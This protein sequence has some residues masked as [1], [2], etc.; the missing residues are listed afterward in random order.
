M[1]SIK[2]KV[3]PHAPSSNDLSVINNFF[4]SDPNGIKVAKQWRFIGDVIN[5]RSSGSTQDASLNGLEKQQV[6]NFMDTA[7]GLEFQRFRSLVRKAIGE[8][9]LAVNDEMARRCGPFS[10]GRAS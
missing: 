3:A 1:E 7:A 5:K 10:S 2:E 4:S 9:T 8:A 6:Q